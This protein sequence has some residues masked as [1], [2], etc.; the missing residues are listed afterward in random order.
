MVVRV[1]CA[2][3]EKIYRLGRVHCPGGRAIQIIIEPSMELAS[4]I[5][6]IVCYVFNGLF[7]KNPSAEPNEPVAFA[8]TFLML[9]K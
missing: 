1:I 3:Y 4:T 6:A 2:I 7:A 5:S 8:N 9:D